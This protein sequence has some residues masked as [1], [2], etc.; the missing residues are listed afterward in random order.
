[1]PKDVLR[2]SKCSVAVIS[3]SIPKR[4][5]SSLSFSKP[6]SIP[7]LVNLGVDD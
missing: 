1:M 3:R 7:R 5:F 2:L 4:S 6:W